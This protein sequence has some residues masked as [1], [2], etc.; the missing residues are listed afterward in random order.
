MSSPEEPQMNARTTHV[1]LP[2]FDFP[3]NVNSVLSFKA[4]VLIA[5]VTCAVGYVLYCWLAAA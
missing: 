3:G 2:R 1:E 5:T 4:G